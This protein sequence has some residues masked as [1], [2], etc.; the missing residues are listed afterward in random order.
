MA[1]NALIFGGRQKD[2][3]AS[4]HPREEAKVD[5]GPQRWVDV[6]G[7]GGPGY[8]KSGKMQMEDKGSTK[9]LSGTRAKGQPFQRGLRL[10][11]ASQT[12][13]QLV[14]QEG[15]RV[16][17]LVGCFLCHSAC[18]TLKRSRR[19]QRRLYSGAEGAAWAVLS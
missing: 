6:M 9:T 11:R 8:R 10:H 15:G 17:R 18:S 16:Q 12:S 19:P 14:L 7:G 3:P 1:G 4:S 2:S 13:K 5:L